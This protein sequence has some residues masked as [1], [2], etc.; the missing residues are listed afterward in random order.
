[1]NYQ[2]YLISK[3]LTEEQAKTVIDGMAENKF[4]LASEENLDERYTKLKAQKEGLETQIRTNQEELE[5]LKKDSEGNAELTKQLTELQMAFDNS[6]AE[7]ETAL[8][9]QQKEF[10]IKLVLKDSETLD[11]D[12]VMGLLNK[13]SINVTDDGLHGLK[14]QLEKIQEEKPYLFQKTESENENPDTPN[15]VTRGNAIGRDNKNLSDP[16]AAKLA[17]YE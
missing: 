8:K 17:K 9:E 12:I 7:S 1:M 3:G 11:T 6:K 16:F 5:K 4:Y 14:E 13:D 15:I 2:E 10:A